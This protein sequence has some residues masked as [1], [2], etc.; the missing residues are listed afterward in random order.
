MRIARNTFFESILW[1]VLSLAN[2]SVTY[3]KDKTSNLVLL[4]LRKITEQM[5]IDMVNELYTR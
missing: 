3:C 1:C 4:D 2:L 5:D